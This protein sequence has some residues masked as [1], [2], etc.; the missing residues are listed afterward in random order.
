MA[1]QL[2]CNK[3]ALQ[4]TFFVLNTLPQI[5]RPHFSLRGLG[6]KIR[7]DLS[8]GAPHVRIIG[9]RNINPSSFF[10]FMPHAPA[11]GRNKNTFVG[12]YTRS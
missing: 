12:G 6:D 9:L 4:A 2:L 7:Q 11:D 1:L 3:G 8:V 5:R 10:G